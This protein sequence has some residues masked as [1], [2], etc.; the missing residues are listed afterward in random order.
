MPPE[1]APSGESPIYR[2]E[3]VIHLSRSSLRQLQPATLLGPG[4]TDRS[5]AQALRRPAAVLV[6]FPRAG[7]TWLRIMLAHAFERLFA[8]R[9][10][11]NPLDT[12][13][14]ART[15]PRI[16]RVI[17]TS[18]YCDPRRC[19]PDDIPTDLKWALKQRIVLLARD[20]RDIAVSLY[21]DRTSRARF[22]PDALPYRGS[23]ADF[24][25]EPRGGLR[26]IIA[27]YNAW[28][29]HA[30]TRP[31]TKDGVKLVKY[32]HLHDDPTLEFGR[33]LAFLDLENAPD[34]VDEM[35]RHASFDQVRR[36]ET[37]GRLGYKPTAD[38]LADDRALV[39]RR[40]LPR[41]Y[42]DH[43]TRE[44]HDFADQALATLDPW[45]DYSA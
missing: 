11:R 13:A 22:F 4:V 20:P 43:F 28:A 26:T 18:G 34:F 32:E 39:L 1:P 31:D 7:R 25:R 2:F 3:Q 41:G 17:V 14:Y 10:P 38:L 45:Y 9:T 33:L 24:I 16:P 30:R 27:F 37:S 29:D 5:L 6:S 21:F 12:D 44:D 42:M 35:V 19:K 36:M 23:L 15:E 40:G 8:T